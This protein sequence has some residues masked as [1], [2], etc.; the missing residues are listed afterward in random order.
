MEKQI[1]INEVKNSGLIH[2]EPQ[3]KDYIGGIDSV[4]YGTVSPLEQPPIVFQFNPDWNSVCKDTELQFNPN[5]DTY[6]CVIF[7]I[8]K[9]TRWYLKKVYNVDTTISEM[10]NAYFAHVQAGRGT[11][12]HDG[13]ES[14]RNYGW[15]KD[16]EYPFT[17]NTILASDALETIQTVAANDLKYVNDLLK[18]DSDGNYKLTPQQIEWI[19]ATINLW[20]KAGQFDNS[21]EHIIWT[22]EEI[23]STETDTSQYSQVIN[24]IKL[25]FQEN[26]N[27]F[28]DA[29]RILMDYFTT[30]VEKAIEEKGGSKEKLTQ[31]K[32]DI[33]WLTSRTISIEH[34]DNAVPQLIHLFTQEAN[35]K[36]KHRATKSI[37]KLM[38]LFKNANLTNYDVFAQNFA[39]DDDRLTG[40]L[41]GK[42]TQLYCAQYGYFIYDLCHALPGKQHPRRSI[43]QS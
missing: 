17:I 25:Q 43:F 27:K 2:E 3:P 4:S 33:A 22:R 6:S 32:K 12:I 29:H 36:A 28:D 15:V 1:I 13:M 14:F 35:L 10:Y 8:A 18:K 21:M 38:E 40:N 34:I 19:S 30:I 24:N 23:D 16:E 41:V 31:L 9:A 37:E 7:A 20:R 39:N 11:T 5:F 26:A 42:Y